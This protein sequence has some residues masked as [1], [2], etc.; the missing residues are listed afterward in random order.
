MIVIA[1]AVGGGVVVVSVE[2]EGG[3][4]VGDVLV[5]ER[6]MVLVV[7]EVLVVVVEPVTVVE[8]L[9]SV[10]VVNVDVESARIDT[11][12][13]AIDSELEVPPPPG[14]L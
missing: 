1:G 2:V 3:E 4:S 6:V 14:P 11:V 13:K 8:G 7:I 9:F 5:V 12:E 10:T